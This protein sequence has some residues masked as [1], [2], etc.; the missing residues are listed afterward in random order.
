MNFSKLRTFLDRL[1]WL[2]GVTAALFLIAVLCLIIIQM[3][4]RWTG[5]IF[6]GAPEYAGY[7]MA[8][9]SFFAFAYAL[10]RG[11]HI[12]VSLLLNALGAKMQRLVN[13]WCF[14]IG[15]AMAW[16]FSFYAVKMTY[17][18]WKLNDISQGQDATPMWIPQITMVIGVTIF[19][20]ALTDHL[21]HL[22]F[23]G[24]HRISAEKVQPTGMEGA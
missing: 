20:V 14:T 22:I 15:G 5:E 3:L 12:R 11:S 13:I 17:W 2:S 23:A 21:L 16:Y 8:A 1:Y 7:S 18:S 4:A 9:S 19:A 6:P 24:D 10:N